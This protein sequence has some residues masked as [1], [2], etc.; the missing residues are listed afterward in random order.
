MTAFQHQQLRAIN[1]SH[2]RLVRLDLKKIV[3]TPVKKEWV[4]ALLQPLTVLCH[5]VS[6][7]RG[8][9]GSISVGYN[10]KLH[11]VGNHTDGSQRFLDKTFDNWT[12]LIISI[13]FNIYFYITN[14]WQL[15]N[16]FKGFWIYLCFEWFEFRSAYC[17]LRNTY[18]SSR[19]V[20]F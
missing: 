19:S 1:Q 12:F 3:T 6:K 17:N 13:F 10:K 5:L 15:I 11:H 9:E 8:K 20:R 4:E 14:Q 18:I 2:Q 16:R 7:Y